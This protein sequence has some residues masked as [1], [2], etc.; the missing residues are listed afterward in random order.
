VFDSMWHS[1]EK[2]AKEIMEAFLSAGMS[3]KLYDLKCSDNSD[4]IADILDAA[5][6]CVGSPTLNNQML[7]TVASFLTYLKGLSPKGRKAMAFGSYGWSG[8][9]I[10]L[11][12]EA[13]VSGGFEIFMPRVRTAYIPSQE[14]LADIRGKVLEGIGHEPQ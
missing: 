6:L 8:Q 4:I 3:A 2:I 1:T 12:E 11:V 14:T 13:L 10:G 7:P 9:S 5:Y